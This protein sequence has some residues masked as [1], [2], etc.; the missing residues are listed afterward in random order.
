MTD[1]DTLDPADDECPLCGGPLA[2]DR[3]CAD[4]TCDADEETA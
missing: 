1:D 2:S 4:D 3:V